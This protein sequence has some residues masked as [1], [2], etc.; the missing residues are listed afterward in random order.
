MPFPALIVWGA[1]A[2]AAALGVKKGLDAKENFE[3]AKSIGRNA[4]SK[5]NKAKHALDL[6]R[7]NTQKALETL[8]KIKVSIFTNQIRYFVEM[9]EKKYKR[10]HSEI[11]GYEEKIDLKSIK[12]LGSLV[13]TSLDI[14]KSLG[15]GAAT[16]ALA[17][18]GAY[19]GVGALATASTGTAIGSLSGVAATNATLAWLGGGSLAAGGF[20]IAGGMVALG[21]VVLGPALAVGG[22]LMANKSEHAL[23]QAEEYSANVDK[24]VSQMKIIQTSLKAIRTASAELAGNL[25]KLAKRFDQLRVEDINDDDKFNIMVVAGKHLKNALGIKILTNE[26]NLNPNIKMEFSGFVEVGSK[27]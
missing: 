24:A 19:G 26:G 2:G 18:F 15:Q 22:F 21:G 14:E 5:Y 10:S 11:K 20:G 13:Q 25:V 27:N 16:G 12:E 9:V 4:E 17:A 7:K 3:R 1:A 23:T 6:D 8:G